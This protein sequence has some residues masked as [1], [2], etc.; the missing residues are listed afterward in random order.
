MLLHV[1][2]SFTGI[3]RTV[4]RLL[5]RTR[6]GYFRVQ[7]SLHLYTIVIFEPPQKYPDGLRLTLYNKGPFSLQVQLLRMS[8]FILTINYTTSFQISAK[9]TISSP[10]WNTDLTTQL[11]DA[12]PSQ[13]TTSKFQKICI[14]FRSSS[15]WMH[16]PSKKEL[17]NISAQINFILWYFYPWNVNLMVSL[18][19]TI[20][21]RLQELF[22]M[23][24]DYCLFRTVL[25][26]YW[27]EVAAFDRYNSGERIH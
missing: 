23:S 15:D 6:T 19:K 5:L 12:L 16:N 3:A 2:H 10:S 11:N 1:G 9:M 13:T 14:Q 18:W 27:R 24:V 21:L 22:E 7:Q 8:W 4:S 20:K 26:L 17:C 25:C